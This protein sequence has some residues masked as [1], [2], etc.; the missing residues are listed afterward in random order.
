M[1][2]EQE[3]RAISL[4]ELIAEQNRLLTSQLQIENDRLQTNKDDLATQQD[5][6]NII[7]DQSQSLKFQKAEKS[8]ILR[9]T[10]SIAKI[11]EQLSVLDRKEL[12]SKKLS[13]KL[14]NDIAKVNKD[15]RL[16]QITKNKILKDQ[17]GLTI[18]Q[19]EVNYDLASSI[20]E[21]IEKA[22]NLKST[23]EETS[24]TTDKL[25]S[26][27]GSKTFGFLDDLSS[28][29]PGLSSISKPLETAADA[30]RNMASGIESAAMSGGKGLTKE[31]IKQLGLEKELENLSGA[32]AASKLKGMSSM[33]KGMLSL[34]SGF[35]ALGPTLATTFGPIALIAKLVSV[36]KDSDKAT[37][38]MAKS[39]NMSYSDAL[40]MR[41][42]LTNAAA[43]SGSLFVNTKGMQES[44]MA[45]NSSLGTNVMLS[46]EMLTQMT[47]MRE[48][49]GFT[50]EELQGIA[51]ISLTTGASMNDVTG[52]FM[53]QAKLA[54]IQNG[55]LLNEKDLLKGI[56]DVSAATTLSL[57]KNP[58]LIGKAVATAKSL[59][60][61]LS[62]VDAIAESL[63]S[64]ES[65]IGAELEAELLIGK[66]L[67]LEKARQASLNNDLATVAEEIAKQA[68]S[69]A[70]FGK[71]NRIEQE[72]LAKAV[73]MNRE[74]LASSLFLREQL[75]G[76][77]GDAAKQA[78]ADYQRRVD[79]LG[80][81]GAQRELEEKGVDGLRNQVGMADKLGAVMSK[82]EEIFVV[83]GQ[84]LMPIFDIFVS[85]FDIVG[86]IM[87]L[88]NPFIQFAATGFSAIA[89]VL[90]LDFGFT[91]TIASIKRTEDASQAVFG[92]SLDIYGRYG[93]GGKKT[94][95]MNSP[96]NGKTMVSTKEG[97]LFEL[98][99]NDDLVAFPGASKMANNTS[100]GGIN[101]EPL[102]TRMAAVENVL[103]Q[104]LQKETGIYLDSNK[105]GKTMQLSNSRMG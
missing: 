5:I 26:N 7:K 65:S 19:V 86:P 88:L 40:Q 38:E 57:G 2:S 28:K 99:P 23:L 69:T 101:I 84:A 17:Q 24:I 56:K 8:A 61:E 91:K 72:A 12:G 75:Q 68:G 81:T 53:A 14:S 102:V 20:D 58:E 52:E 100:S 13:L 10:N 77:T 6:S 51:A 39:M 70:E 80:V 79:I 103:I 64:F 54:S 43:S 35:K 105:I 46:G 1:A 18:K 92:T 94:G 21:Q 93:A 48:M 73:G 66:Q 25:S 96:A 32:A 59:G 3:K 60:M 63:L 83:V 98:S 16:L 41:S 29:I 87:K 67:N 97:G 22:L 76:L 9:S 30:S 95:D 37:S 47:E 49:A 34:T 85:I 90:S 45:I 15:V 42:E 44:L 27:F 74:E 71:M 33:R 4:K 78:E 36:I 55:V 82:L 50:N 104:I 31:R 62:K 89:D 11:Q